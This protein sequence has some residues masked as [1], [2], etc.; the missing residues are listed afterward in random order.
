MCGVRPAL[1]GPI[2]CFVTT[3]R[4]N[5]TL[6]RPTRQNSLTTTE[7]PGVNAEIHNNKTTGINA[8]IH[9]NNHRH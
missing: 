3:Y 5:N 9:I 6:H 7:T 4:G 8:E 1:A 2:Q